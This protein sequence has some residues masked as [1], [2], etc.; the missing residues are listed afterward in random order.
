MHRL[1]ETELKAATRI[2]FIKCTTIPHH[3]INNLKRRPTLLRKHD[4]VQR[5]YHELVYIQPI[6]M[7]IY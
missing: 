2:I 1:T 3:I 7:L 6:K 5:I 4:G